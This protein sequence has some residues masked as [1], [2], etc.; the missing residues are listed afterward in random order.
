MK[1]R[2]LLMFSFL[3]LFLASCEDDVDKG[4][5]WDDPHFIR[6]TASLEHVSNLGAD[7][8]IPWS[9][10]DTLYVFDQTGAGVKVG[11]NDPAS[12]IFFSYGWTAGDP[13][14]AVFPASAATSV[15]MDGNA[16]VTLPAGQQ[17]SRVGDFGP[18]IALGKVEGNRTAYKL[19]GMKNA[20][21]FVKVSMADSTARSIT[22][23]P[24]A[25]GEYLAGNVAVDYQKLV[26]DG[27]GYWTPVSTE[28][29]SR[30]VTLTAAPGTDAET[31]DNCLHAGGYYASVLPQTYSEGLKITV[32]YADG[33]SLVRILNAE[34]GLV[35]PR[36]GV[37]AFEGTLD[38]TLPD[39][40][41]ISLDFYNDND[42]NPLGT[43]IEGVTN[44][45]AAGEEYVWE[46]KYEFEG[47]DLS[48]EF[49]FVVSKGQE[50]NA[51]YKY[52]QPSNL[53]HKLLF[54]P[55]NNSWI[56]LPGIPG[57][58][59]KSVSMSHDNTSAK[60]F[61]MQDAP[62]TPGP[63]GKY[64]SSPLLKATASGT[65]IIETVTFPTE[66]TDPN[67]L[68]STEEGKSYTMQFTSGASLRI[69][70]ITLVYSKTLE[71]K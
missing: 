11:T 18:V 24:V 36:A 21:G 61:R 69:W 62:P 32:T 14:I 28:G 65:P 63:V 17:I 64:Y 59:L 6:I 67:Q 48:K 68:K 26:A 37:V 46:Y 38:D 39:E 8:E 22:I 43:F 5:V 45:K 71:T 55:K 20:L 60:R 10:S 54:T 7:T 2:F 49:T 57:R 3:A 9:L 29:M 53:Q 31:A 27:I 25:D 70:N 66:T 16:C 44:Q 41:V 19:P 1:T 40:I 47:Q 12:N 4:T 33:Q 13:G 56:K 23:E 30:T 50:A 51:E 52:T 34:G 58:Y 35:V 42:I 15:S